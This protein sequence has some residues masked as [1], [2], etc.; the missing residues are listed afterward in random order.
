MIARDART[1]RLALPVDPAL[2]ARFFRALAHTVATASGPGAAVLESSTVGTQPSLWVRPAELVGPLLSAPVFASV[3]GPSGTG[4]RPAGD[5]GPC[6]PTADWA[7]APVA[8][9]GPAAPAA[10]PMDVPE[11]GCLLGP[12]GRVDLQTFWLSGR[13]DGRLWIARTARFVTTRDDELRRR[14]AVVGAF[15]AAEWSRATGVLCRPRPLRS[16]PRRWARADGRAFAA[17]DWLAVP[18]AVGARTAEPRVPDGPGALEPTDAHTVALGSTGSGKTTFLAERAAQ[19]IRDGTAV[20]VVDLH[21]DLAPAIVARLAPSE[22]SSVVAV[23]AGERPVVGVAALHGTDGRAAAQFVA[24]I[25]RLS[26]DGADVY[27][28]FRLERIF[29]AFVRLVQDGGGSLGD[30]YAL[31]TDADRRDAAR[32]ATSVPELARFLDE[33]G[34]VVRRNPE[35]LWSAAARLAKVVLVPELAE[36][37]APGDGGVPVEELLDARRSLLVRIPFARLGPEAASFAGSLIVARTYLGVTARLPPAGRP[38][39]VLFVLDEV[40]GL[41]PRLVA[42]MLAEGRK[43]GV[44]CLL[45]TQYPERLAPELRL[46]ASGA[47]GGSVVFRVPRAT[48]AGVGPW[49]GLSRLEAEELLPELPVGLG[50]V[51]SPVGELR[52]VR[53]GPTRPPAT[54]SGWTEA[55]EATRR[56]HPT[57]ASPAPTDR[58]AATE[59]LL[60]AALAAEER[61]APVP[62]ARW[63]E[64]AARLPGEPIDAA[65]LDDRRSGVERG[66]WVVRS[67]GAVRLTPAGERRL[68]LLAATGASRESAEHRALLLRAFRIFA[69]HGHRLEIVRQGRYDTTLP[70]ARFLQL[71]GRE[72]AGSPRELAAAV[73]GAER[74]WA[75]RFFGG[76][77]VHVEAEVSGALRAERVRHGWQKARSRGAYALFVVGDGGR[78]AR[79]RRVLGALGVGRDR[80]QVWVLPVAPRPL[81]DAGRDG[82]APGGCGTA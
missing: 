51:R 54:E 66:G 25:K 70:D 20:V 52:T 60:L 21:G 47:T 9:P 27:W 5:A 22:R 24:A 12:T 33:L 79:I 72:R 67:E 59:R 16:D 64:E 48:A 71:A 57:P 14:A 81:T 28:G 31:L 32:L 55:V 68:G 19:A 77:D 69:R 56:E 41:S 30:L 36:L 80:A 15:V 58:D 39:E 13:T 35:F 7:M 23:D 53:T 50:L 37:L 62:Y 3:R 42:E 34:P 11:S 1:L 43:F 75:W 46:A 65:V 61:D 76:L 10:G 78:A 49:L 82:K 73:A 6:G 63:G 8:L 2:R 38:R 4:D 45:A 18:P 29:D 74:T 26:P 44:R 17:S 40:Q